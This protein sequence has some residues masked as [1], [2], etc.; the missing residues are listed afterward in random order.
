MIT[1]MGVLLGIDMQGFSGDDVP[2][3]VA[4]QAA[5][6][7]S[8]EPPSN[9]RASEAPKPKEPEDVKMADP[10]PAEDDEETKAKR[11][12]EAEKQ[13]GSE[14]YK[15]KEFDVAA[16]AFERAWELWPKDVT[17]LTNLSG[18]WNRVCLSFS[19]SDHICSCLS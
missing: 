10:E 9:P 7:S 8:S 3:D 1:V 6:P 11:E 4:A 2:P 15:K 19:Y 13:K 12:A 17:F 18:L 5:T 16:K 14:A